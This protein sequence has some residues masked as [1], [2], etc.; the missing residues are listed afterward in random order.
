MTRAV[1][2]AVCRELKAVAEPAETGNRP[3]A[4]PAA[5]PAAVDLVADSPAATVLG[6]ASGKGLPAVDKASRVV[7]ALPEHWPDSRAWEPEAAAPESP[8]V[9]RPARPAGA[10]HSTAVEAAEVRPDSPAGWDIEG[11]R[12]PAAG[13]AARRVLGKFPQ[14]GCRRVRTVAL[15]SPLPAFRSRG[16]GDRPVPGGIGVPRALAVLQAAGTADNLGR[17]PV[18]EVAK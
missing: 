10:V 7:A 5:G 12:P 16:P 11:V 2:P 1:E 8:G 17:I 3:A 4:A 15:D 18:V 13:A 6:E 14:D 9:D